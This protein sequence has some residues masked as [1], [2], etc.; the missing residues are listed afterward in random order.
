M[1]AAASSKEPRRC[2]TPMLHAASGATPGRLP[3][4]GGPGCVVACEGISEA[5]QRRILELFRGMA[6]I[7]PRG[8]RPGA[9]YSQS[10]H[11]PTRI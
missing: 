2:P 6:R 9:G 3:P 10:R 11:C 4:E 1:P 7:V 5:L 8:D